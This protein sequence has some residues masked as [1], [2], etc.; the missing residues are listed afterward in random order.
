[1]RRGTPGLRLADSCTLALVDKKG[2]KAKVRCQLKTEQEIF[3]SLSGLCSTT[4]YVQAMA[5]LCLRDN[6]I[7]FHTSVEGS[8]LSNMYSENRL[9]RTEQSTL[10]GLLVKH[11]VIDTTMPSD[12]RLEEYT[13]TTQHL[14]EQLHKAIGRPMV[15]SIRT[16]VREQEFD[17]D[18]FASGKVLREVIYYAGETAYPYQYVDLVV[19]KYRRDN[20]WLR[21]NKGFSIEDAREVVL[22]IHRALNAQEPKFQS[23]PHTMPTPLSVCTVRLA[24]V[25]R[26]SKLPARIVRKVFAAFSVELSDSSNSDFN[27]INDFNLI[28]ATPLVPVSSKNDFFLF[29]TTVLSDSLY[30]SPYY[31]MMKDKK[32]RNVAAS[33][34]GFFAEDVV[35]ERLSKVFGPHRVYKNVT[36]SS[37]RTTL[38]EIDVLVVYGTRA[39]VAQVKSKQLTLEARR[40]NDN[41]I[42]GDFK[43]SIQDSYDQ[44]A[45]CAKYI[46]DS[47]SYEIIDANSQA[48]DFG[49]GISQIYPVSVVSDHYPGLAL[50]VR[51]FLNFTTTDSLRP[52]LVLD[53]FM[54]DT[55]TEMLESPVEL[56][57]YLK[58]RVE[59]LD[60]VSAQDELV[61]LSFHLQH[62]LLLNIKASLVMMAD[63]ISMDLDAAMLVRRQGVLGDKDVDGYLKMFRTTSV[64]RLRSSIENH[65]DP[66]MIELAFVLMQLDKGTVLKLSSIIDKAAE[67][68]RSDGSNHDGSMEF[69]GLDAGLTVHCN[70]E[71]INESAQF[72]TEHSKMRK[73]SRRVKTWFGVLIASDGAFRYG[74]SLE[75]D[76]QYDAEMETK[77][78]ALERRS[79]ISRHKRAT[80]YPGVGRNEPCPCGS[81]RKY[82]HCCLPK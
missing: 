62:N 28:N 5:L 35:Y 42:R 36:I 24:E 3:E 59:N 49:T 27:S 39:I 51:T 79:A 56:L 72:L 58:L 66:E 26:R 10:V 9:V 25:I 55:I 48:I 52:P 16:S 12:E 18:P 75:G 38:G 20:D 70:P 14:L 81:G 68:S 29:N 78:A 15:D 23:E 32:Y 61:I 53:V 37:G 40:G 41:Q 54:L 65:N 74:M 17:N 57:S 13:N 71:S 30:T 77:V 63:E 33:H 31:W 44:A 47:E 2:R 80:V 60:I 4:G 7:R 6:V 22:D 82:K 45:S 69:A 46:G 8:D 67:L 50:Q 34:R 43:K 73:Y 76:W 11:G 64:G 21:A 19:R 1:M